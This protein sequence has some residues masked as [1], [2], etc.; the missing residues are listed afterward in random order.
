MGTLRAVVAVGANAVFWPGL[1][2]MIG[3]R[4]LLGF[5]QGL[6]T[7]LIGSL[8]TV[9]A[10]LGESLQIA[11]FDAL[12]VALLPFVAAVWIWGMVTIVALIR[13]EKAPPSPP[14]A[15]SKRRRRPPAPAELVPG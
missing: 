14:A 11:T 4:W 8:M 12:A 13:G 15:K 7:L 3:G 10:F 9:F 6:L 1:G 5:M 2:T